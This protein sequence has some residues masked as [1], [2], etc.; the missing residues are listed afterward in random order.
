MGSASIIGAENAKNDTE[1]CFGKNRNM[2]RTIDAVMRAAQRLWPRKTA[3]ELSIR[4][5]VSVRACEYWL[6]RKT[7]MSA[8]A[9]ASLLRSDAGLDVLEAIIGDA[10]P[11]WW[12]QFALTIE[13]SKARKQ[14]EQT[15]AR[16]ERMEREFDL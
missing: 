1:T 16:L 9:L 4:S 14:Q 15:R 7:D 13:I 8:D 10:K 2:L 3:A 12:K 5:G 6:S 11:K